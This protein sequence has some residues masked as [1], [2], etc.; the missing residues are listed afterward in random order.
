MTP[1][2]K[3][4]VQGVSLVII[5]DAVASI[6]SKQ[7]GIPYGDL[8]AGS[9]FIYAVVGFFAS[10]INEK[11]SL[12]TA[13]LAGAFIGFTDATLGW[14]VSYL[15]GPGRPAR[16]LTPLLWVFVAVTVTLSGAAL[17]AVGCGIEK[18]LSRRVLVR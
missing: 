9:L 7:F 10:R 17:A 14:L 4:L 13:I 8:T 1:T 11:R 15:I 3:L 18:L 12:V 2:K 5:Y 16:P 6:I